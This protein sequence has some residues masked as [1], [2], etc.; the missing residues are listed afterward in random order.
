MDA[1]REPGV[2][3]AIEFLTELLHFIRGQELAKDYETK[4]VEVVQ[5]LL[6]QFHRIL[7]L[8]T[9]VWIPDQS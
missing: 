8:S 7:S 5:L 6:S 4:G 1:V 9:P 3:F 2:E